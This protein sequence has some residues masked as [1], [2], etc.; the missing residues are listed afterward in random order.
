MA[1][2]HFRLISD[3]KTDGT[4]ISSNQHLQYIQREG[5]FSHIDHSHENLVNDKI[6]A[7]TND[8]LQN[9]LKTVTVRSMYSSFFA[10]DEDAIKKFPTVSVLKLLCVKKLILSDLQSAIDKAVEVCPYATFD[11]SKRD[12]I[13]YFHKNN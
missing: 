10:A 4:R 13:V 6:F 9:Y 12:G 5:A 2:F 8:A 1:M 3:K 11:I 7:A